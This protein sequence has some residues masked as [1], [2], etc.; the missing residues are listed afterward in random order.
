MRQHEMQARRGD[1]AHAG[2]VAPQVINKIAAVV[3]NNGRLL[4]VRKAQRPP[5]FILPGGKPETGETAGETLVRELDEELG[6][7][8]TSH[9]LFMRFEDVAHFERSVIRVGAY[10]VEMKGV[11]TPRSEI[12]AVHWLDPSCQATGINVASGISRHVMPR[13][14]AQGLIGDDFY[15]ARDAA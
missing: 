12:A 14:R 8:V 6:V 9:E 7:S 3:V 4:V 5:V 13:L 1:S 11:P 15:T 2:D 10:F